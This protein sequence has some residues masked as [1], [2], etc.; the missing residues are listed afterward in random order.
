MI[1]SALEDPA[2]GAQYASFLKLTKRGGDNLDVKRLNVPG[3]CIVQVSR[4]PW[5]PASLTCIE[6]L[7]SRRLQARSAGRL[8]RC[9]PV[10][11]SSRPQRAPQPGRPPS[12]LCRP[13]I[14]SPHSNFIQVFEQVARIFIHAI[15]SGP[16]QFFLPVPA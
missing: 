10:K 6:P 2:S 11:S 9:A 3:V 12:R 13:S 7:L 1:L 15:G 14:R 8:M 5:M 16:L 4:T